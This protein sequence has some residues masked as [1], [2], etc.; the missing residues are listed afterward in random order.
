MVK[1]VLFG[2]IRVRQDQGVIHDELHHLHLWHHTGGVKL[3]GTYP[4]SML[5]GVDPR[6][7]QRYIDLHNP[8]SPKIQHPPC[9]YPCMLHSE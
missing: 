8:L 9:R 2:E 5:H 3:P 4:N 7:A 6:H 1:E